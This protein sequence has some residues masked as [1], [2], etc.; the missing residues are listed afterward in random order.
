M[1]DIKSDWQ[2]CCISFLTKKIGLRAT[3]KARAN[4]N[5]VLPHE[6]HKPVIKKFDKRKVYARFKENIQ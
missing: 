3:N 2:V 1:T 4:V 6:L 5:K